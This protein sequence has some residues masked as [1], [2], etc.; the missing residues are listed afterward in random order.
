MAHQ[1]EWITVAGIKTLIEGQATPEQIPLMNR[2][3][4]LLYNMVFPSGGILGLYEN[5]K[6][7]ALYG[8][9]YSGQ[10]DNPRVGRNRGMVL[11]GTPEV[12]VLVNGLKD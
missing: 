7:F 12:R 5:I 6:Q 11:R 9:Y 4:S 8:M 2:L 10:I 1:E 3:K